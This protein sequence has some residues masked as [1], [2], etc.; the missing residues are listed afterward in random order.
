MPARTISLCALASLC[1]AVGAA[2]LAAQQHQLRLEWS[3]NLTEYRGQ[4][5]RRITHVC[6]PQGT[7]MAVYGTDSYTDDSGACSAAVHAGLIT[8]AEGGVVT[9]VIGPGRSSY[10]GSARNGVTSQSFGSWSGSFSFDRS[11]AEGRVDW[12]TTG[13]GVELARRPLTV[14]CPPGG[15]STTV[16]GT[17]IYTEDSPVC[18]AAVHAG[19]ITSSSGGRVTV[20]AAGEQPSY[21]ASERNGVQ[22][23]DYNGT[24]NGFRVSAAGGTAMAT[25]T[26][27]SAS[28]ATPTRTAT[29]PT[30]RTVDSASRSGR[31]ATTATTTTATAGTTS[32]RTPTTVQRAP[33]STPT[34]LENVA[35]GP[36]QGKLAAVA[37]VVTT[38]QLSIE[39]RYRRQV[40]ADTLRLRG[41]R[42]ENI[43]ITTDRL[44]ITGKAP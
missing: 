22:S 38:P 23:R 27:A 25:V 34:T 20:E 16:W 19:L 29:A 31:I 36:V 12:G 11:G 24:P 39:G 21:A 10:V 5:G 33:S 13:E 8:V 14:V 26:S 35:A 37:R 2:P 7:L 17:D 4:N 32:S 18:V 3:K 44:T 30:L 1:L 15:E 43:A 6:P 41:R 42:I 9:I 28:E 40:V